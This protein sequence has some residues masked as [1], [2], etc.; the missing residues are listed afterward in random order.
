MIKRFILPKMPT[1]AAAE[2][3]D[4]VR[5]EAFEALSD[6]PQFPTRRKKHV[7]VIRHDAPGVERISFRTSEQDGVL[8]NLRR[9]RVFQIE[10]SFR[11]RVE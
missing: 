1:A 4:F 10:R 5:R 6:F 11:R 3:V 9:R 2:C 7:D 8:D